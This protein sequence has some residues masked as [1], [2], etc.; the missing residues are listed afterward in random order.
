MPLIDTPRPCSLDTV[1][2]LLGLSYAL[3]GMPKRIVDQPVGAL[4]YVAVMTLPV[5][6]V[7]PALWP[8]DKHHPHERSSLATTRSSLA[9]AA[10]RR[11][12]FAGDA[13]RQPKQWCRS[14][15]TPLISVLLAFCEHQRHVS[16]APAQ[17]WKPG[18]RSPRINQR[19]DPGSQS[20]PCCA[21]PGW[22]H[23]PR[24]WRRSCH[25]PRLA[26][27]LLGGQRPAALHMRVRPTRHMA[28]KC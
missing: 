8:K 17:H 22:H 6:A 2:Q 19:D 10:N 23:W 27:V 20:P 12:A 9:A 14:S 16:D 24:R 11:M 1:F 25:P 13:K 21:W 4:D 7:F 15:G 28:D 5:G 18:P 26:H 3:V